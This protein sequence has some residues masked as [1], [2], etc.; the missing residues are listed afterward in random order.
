[1]AKE[2]A[3]F[4]A[5]MTVSPALDGFSAGVPETGT[6]GG[7]QLRIYKIKEM[8]RCLGLFFQSW[9]GRTNIKSFI[10]SD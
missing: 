4:Q 6:D 3:K 5:G 8:V 9:F 7:M 2:A 10:N 1:M